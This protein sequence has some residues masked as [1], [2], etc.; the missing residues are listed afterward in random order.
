M[1]KTIT[2]LIALSS[3]LAVAH[4]LTGYDCGGH[5]LNITT[6]SL[7]NIEECKIDNIEPK[8]EEVYVQLLQL[9]EFEHTFGYQCKIEIDR[10]IYYCG[11]HSHITAVT[12]D[13]NICTIHQ[14]TPVGNCMKPEPYP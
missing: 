4:G 10:N 14:Q 11:M 2:A 5:G 3:A 8:K 6:L 13:V 1:M 12:E 7:L 9:S